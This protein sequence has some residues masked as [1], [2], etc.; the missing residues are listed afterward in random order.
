MTDTPTAV[1]VRR[2]ITEHLDVNPS[3]VTDDA[4]LINDLMADSLDIT[5]IGMAIEEEFG[6]EVDDTEFET[7]KTVG[8]IIKKVEEALG[9]E[10]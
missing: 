1:V 6:F 8:D 5:E 7:L 3:Q 2:L 10:S 4:E 9:N